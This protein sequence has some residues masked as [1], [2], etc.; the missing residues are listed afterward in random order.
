[1]KGNSVDHCRRDSKHDGRIRYELFLPPGW[2]ARVSGFMGADERGRT[3][4]IGVQHQ[5][6]VFI[7]MIHVNPYSAT[8]PRD[9]GKFLQRYHSDIEQMVAKTRIEV[10]P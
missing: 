4:W 6:I 8:A 10:K 7:Y 1:M 2:E 3:I 5:D 9:P